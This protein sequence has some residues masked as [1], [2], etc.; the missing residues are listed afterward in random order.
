MLEVKARM[1]FFC[2]EGEQL[3]DPIFVASQ[4]EKK[5]KR[6]A[7]RGSALKTF[8][9]EFV[10]VRVRVCACLRVGYLCTVYAQH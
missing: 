2:M 10:C 9:L 5:K 6:F 4:K 1:G 3:P 8:M 7:A